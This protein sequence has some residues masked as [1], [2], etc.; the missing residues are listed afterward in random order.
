MKTGFIMMSKP[1]LTAIAAALAIT[2]S[3]PAQAGEI[4]VN[5]SNS[6]FL[7]FAAAPGNTLEVSS[8]GFGGSAIYCAISCVPSVPDPLRDSSGTALFGPV[9]FFTGT[10]NTG[11]PGSVPFFTPV[12]GS[13][14]EMFT[15]QSNNGPADASPPGT[16]DS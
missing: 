6:G 12:P 8:A 2:L 7:T 4:L 9:D 15:Y 11:P 5:Q 3:M 16:P 14:S 1:L 10:V 13:T